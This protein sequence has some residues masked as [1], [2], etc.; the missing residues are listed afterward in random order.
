MKEVLKMN[1]KWTKA[2]IADQSDKVVI[3]T[4]AS[5]GLGYE[6]ALVLAEKGGEVILAVRNQHKGK[7]AVEAI[8]KAFPQAKVRTM[9]LDLADLASIRNFA[10]D[11]K[12]TY[13][14]LDILINNAGIMIPPH[15]LTKDGFESQFGANHLGHF[16]LTGLLLD[17]LIATPQSRVVTLSS[18]AAH[19]GTIDFTNL[20]GVKGYKAIDFYGQS[21]L[22]NMLF[23]KE[24]QHQFSDNQLDTISLTCHPGFARSNLFSRGS[25]KK[26]N[27]ILRFLQNRVSQPA[28]MGALPILYA[29]TE[30]G[31]IGGE[32]I[33]PDGKKKRK[34]YPMNDPIINDLFNQEIA[35]KLWQVS[36]SLTGVSYQFE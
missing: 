1:K 6:T 24:L 34:G 5:S 20:T 33:G 2:K 21:K 28:D 13:K 15:Q 27:P 14:T 19:H 35:E 32:Y 17:R 7:A 12:A 3:V 22:A 10:G 29:A 11:F 23:A 30:P 31:L 8:K 4:G 16:A 26:A 25:G 9:L 36:E 18:L